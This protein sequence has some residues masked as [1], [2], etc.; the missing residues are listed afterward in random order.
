[1]KI[2]AI[3]VAAGSGK[4]FGGKKQFEVIEGKS[5]IELTAEKILTCGRIREI[6][7]VLPDEDV[8]RFRR[9]CTKKLHI[10]SGG[11]TRQHS[12]YNG[13]KTLSAD[14]DIV[15]VHDGVRPLVNRRII[16]DTI[17]GAIKFGA[18]VAGVRVKDTVKAVSPSGAVESTPDRNS[19]YLA[20]TPQ[21][22]R[23]SL[24]MDAYEKAFEDDYYSTDDSAL[25][26]RL[27]ARV[28]IVPGDYKNIKI[29]TK[30][31]IALTNKFFCD[32][33]DVWP[34]KGKNRKNMNDMKIGFGYDIHKFVKGKPLYLGGV[35][36]PFSMGLLAHSDG[37]VLLH[38]VCDSMLGATGLGD[39]GKHFPTK[40]KKYK[41]ISSLKLLE[42]VDGL[43]RE[44]GYETINI[45]T[46]I[47][48]KE[49]KIA[50]YIE[51]MQA[52][53]SKV[54]KTKNISI[55]ATTNEGI[56]DIGKGKAIC[57]HA[58]CALKR[59]AQPVKQR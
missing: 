7:L 45:D 40:D 5:I 31:D 48:A 36:I 51:Q 21:A 30:E 4:R 14:T 6:V 32:E 22:F 37:D 10:I 42:T 11:A 59:F 29:T 25:V 15:L 47:V 24:I 3:I 46:M 56:G 53:I 39:I 50:P 18:V 23:Y 33:N 27:G 13:L 19:L 38:A 35:K 54:L 43:I 2:S 8:A 44:S 52:A 17:E 16:A 49:P 20:Q 1:M 26:E 58:V 34:R 57:A 9:S 28:K 41:N 55:K 12:V